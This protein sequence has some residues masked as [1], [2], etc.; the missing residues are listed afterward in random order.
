MKTKEI[1]VKKFSTKNI[2][3]L[4]FFSLLL[5]S[6]HLKA[7][8]YEHILNFHSDIRVDT[9]GRIDVTET[10]K[11]LV[12]GASIQKGIV[13]TIPLYRTSKY[14]VDK[15]IDIHVGFVYKNGK[16]ENYSTK[17]E[18]KD[19]AIYI[20]NKDVTLIP[21]IYEYTIKYWSR[22]HVGFF[23]NYDEIYWN[24]NGN[25]WAF[26][27]DSISASV[28]LPQGAKFIN[29]A[30]YTGV[31]G[32]TTTDCSYLSIGDTIVE[33]YGNSTFSQKE[34]LTIATSFTPN[35]IKRPPVLDEPISTIVS[36]IYPFRKP[37]LCVLAIVVMLICFFIFKKLANRNRHQT[38]IPQFSAPEDKSPASL[39]YLFKRK[40]D[41]KCFVACILSMAVKNAIK[42]SRK[43][44]TKSTY[45]LIDQKNSGGLS[46][47]E[48]MVYSELFA[49][50]QIV[51]LGNNK[52]SSVR[53][54]LTSLEKILPTCNTIKDYIPSRNIYATLFIL[55]SYVVIILS[56][57]AAHS[58]ADIQQKGIVII[59]VT[60][61]WIIALLPDIK[62]HCLFSLAIPFVSFFQM[63]L[64]LVD[65]SLWYII[66][67]IWSM[68]IIDLLALKFFKP[69][70]KR[71]ATFYSD[72]K[73]FRMYLGVAEQ[74]RLDFLTPPDLTPDQFEKM[75]PY[76]V[77]LDLEIKWIKKFEKIFRDSNY[78]PTWYDYESM[79]IDES[80][81]KSLVDL[82]SLPKSLS[83]QVDKS[84]YE[85]KSDDNW[86]SSSSGSRDWDSG[87]SSDSG[88][89]GSSGGG[90]GGGGGRGW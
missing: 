24:I 53:K 85:H 4:L 80:S 20:G 6:T 45:M 3:Y 81:N 41:Y 73:G 44:K 17:I 76:A 89:S 67:L 9:T 58:F 82:M 87:S 71:G 8:N 16:A 43:D 28:Y 27:I 78:Q 83:Q 15:R 47:E 2:L 72:L 31:R 48:K 40:F 60:S 32:S 18:N 29:N 26:D 69:L 46:E 21:D 61:I 35:I 42:I 57:I 86:S 65:P 64:C 38:V 14:N 79:R 36:L 77:A 51:E 1:S 54:A 30:C 33:F 59:L 63:M 75:L 22:G 12:T 52:A 50:T 5:S 25:D 62:M 84:I 88:S 10:I 37:L 39:R 56:S 66:G 74:K 19:L 90:G 13:R 11:V 68:V 34:G 7:Q 49:R 70:T 23:D 55:L